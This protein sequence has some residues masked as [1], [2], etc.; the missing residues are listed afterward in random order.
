MAYKI[1]II[2]TLLLIALVVSAQTTVNP[3]DTGQWQLIW[4][5]EFN[6][7]N[8]EELLLSWESQNGPN[9]HV[10]C[11]RWEENIEVGDGYI[12]LVNRKE[13]RAGKDW[14]SGNIWTR[15]YFKYGYFECRY[16]YAAAT[17][18]NNS[19]WLTNVS[20][21]GNTIPEPK[22][23]KRFEL[24]VNEGK[25]PNRVDM[26]IHNW[27]DSTINANGKMSHPVYHKIQRFDTVDFS[28]EAHLFG[29]EWTENELV[30]YLDR[31]EIRREKNE[32]CFSPAPIFLSLAITPGAGEITDRIDGTFMEVDYVRV[33]KKQ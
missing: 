17:G 18:T 32:F 14:T 27:S 21:W 22:S 24:D 29:L 26:N 12:R 15:R 7:N 20:V 13:T 33:Y 9:S 16:K 10:P 30:F 8:R 11:S 3:D 23:G 31:K 1:F 2:S 25:Y 6:Y 4:Q 19:F 28:K 5:D